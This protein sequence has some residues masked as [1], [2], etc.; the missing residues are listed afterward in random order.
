MKEKMAPG[1]ILEVPMHHEIGFSSEALDF[2]TLDL[3]NKSNHKEIERE[4]SACME[5]VI[6][7]L[8]EAYSGDFSFE[9]LDNAMNCSNDELGS[10]T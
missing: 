3:E 5:D 7:Y 4:V 2:T 1:K 9:D 8:P 10:D 6:A